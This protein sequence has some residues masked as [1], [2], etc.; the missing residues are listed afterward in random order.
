[1]LLCS[2]RTLGNTRTD[3]CTLT[4]FGQKCHPKCITVVLLDFSSVEEKQVNFL[5]NNA[6]VMVCPYGKTVDGFEMQI[7]VNHMGKYM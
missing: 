7:G 5:I 1:M 2:F 3:E 6:G 4:F